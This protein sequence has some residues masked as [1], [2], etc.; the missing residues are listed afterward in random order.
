MGVMATLIPLVAGAHSNH[1][2]SV[3]V[4]RTC[5][6]SRPPPQPRSCVCSYARPHIH[7]PTCPNTL[8]R[9]HARS[10]V[11]EACQHKVSKHLTSVL[12]RVASISPRTRTIPTSLSASLDPGCV[13][14]CACVRV[15]DALR[16]VQG[17]RIDVLSQGFPETSTL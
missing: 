1:N 9:T 13:C 15:C 5:T 8:A 3:F 2:V 10:P 14:V 12:V 4:R 16:P 6:T 11:Y 7:T 17:G